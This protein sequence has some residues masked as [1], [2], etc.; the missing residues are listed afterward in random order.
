MKK[1]LFFAFGITVLCG[2]AVYVWLGHEMDRG[3]EKKA[4]GENEYVIILG[5]KVKP[6]GVPSLA[7]ANRLQVAAEYLHKHPH[8]IAV[9]SGGQGA[10]ED[11]T[12]A[13]VMKDY[14]LAEGITSERILVEDEATSTYENL[15]Y[16]KRLL[17]DDV[18]NITII[19]NDFH[20]RRASYL[21]EKIGLEA[22]VVAAPTPKIVE[23]KMRFRER[24]ALLKTYI[25]GQ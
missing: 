20:L 21:A 6:G 23:A 7:L 22:D 19:S 9:V 15:L 16:S 17:P 12:E 10:D 4:T 18:T 2:S 11:R 3:V 1:W 13:S 24:L 8:V 5:A 14:L 25:L